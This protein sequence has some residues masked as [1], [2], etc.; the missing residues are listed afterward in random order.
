MQRLLVLGEPCSDADLRIKA[1][2]RLGGQVACLSISLCG[3]VQRW[4]HTPELF[5][6]IVQKRIAEQGPPITLR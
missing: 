5:L 3:G 6:V 2:L 4:V 1:R